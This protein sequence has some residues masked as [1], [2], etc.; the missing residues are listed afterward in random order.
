M[1]AHTKLKVQQNNSVSQPLVSISAD[2]INKQHF[3]LPLQNSFW[4]YMW[5]SSAQA[6]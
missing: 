3:I 5:L 4:M 1:A 6:E 2:T